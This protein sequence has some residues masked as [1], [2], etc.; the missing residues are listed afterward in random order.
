VKKSGGAVFLDA[1]RHPVAKAVK[2]D[3]SHAVLGGTPGDRA[4]LPKSLAD[5]QAKRGR[6]KKE[7]GKGE[8]GRPGPRDV[9]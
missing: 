1:G 2:N 9:S 6:G 8:K 7:K 5:L 3:A 4:R